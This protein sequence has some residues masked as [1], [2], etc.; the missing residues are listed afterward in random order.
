V[1]ISGALTLNNTAAI[2]QACSGTCASPSGSG[3]HISVTNANN[4]VGSPTAAT[5]TGVN[6]QNAQIDA[7]GV[8]F[9]TVNV[10]GTGTGILVTNIGNSGF[11]T[12][13]GTGSA[14]TGGV[15][16]NISARGASF[17]GVKNIN[18]NWMTFTSA[19]TA[20]GA[21]ANGTVGGNENTDENGAIHLVNAVNV[22]ISNVTITTT[23]Q[24]GI[25]GNNVT[26]L[27]LTNVSLSGNGNAVWESGIYLFHL[28]GLASASQD[29]VWNNVD[30]T[31]SGQFNV[32]IIN[33]SGTN[34]APGEKDKLTINNACSF[35]NSGQNVPGDHISNFNSGTAN[36]QIVVNGAAFSSAVGQTSDGIQ[37]D[38]SGSARTDATIINCTFGGSGAG[39]SAINMSA[40]TGIGVFDVESNTATVR[41]A[42]GI[43]VAVTGS[44]S[45]SGTIKAN[46]LSTNVTNNPAQAINIVEEG[47]GTIVTNVESNT[48]NGTDGGTR[49]DVGIRAG[50]RQGSGQAQITLKGNSVASAKSNAF[51]GFAGNGAGGES[52]TTCIKFDT[53]TKNTF[54]GDAAT[55][56]S[57]YELDQ[58]TGTTF[59]LQGFAG[60]GTDATQVETFVKNTDTAPGSRTA[61][62][63][64]GTTVNYSGGTCTTFP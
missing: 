42:V 49:F 48:I 5:T 24:H 22:A 23:A 55:K 50:A 54:R 63:S 47:N 56:V 18:L 16:N 52:N 20:D 2:F 28:K 29:S 17:I 43:N 31:N 11:F 8:T 12:I 30:V 44:G 37:V 36:F 14:G 19:N 6:I 33:A 61:F 60:L 32:S 41:A 15:I 38:A 45:L 59:K 26:N 3:L 62:A 53:T 64:F 9:K 39:Q 46:N 13:A 7:G 10:S 40:S 58:Y 25:N 35:T 27:D 57:D 1:N 51:L 34:A 4:T 21:V